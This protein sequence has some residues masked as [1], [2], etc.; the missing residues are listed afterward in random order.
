[1]CK[2]SQYICTV[3]DYGDL[4]LVGIENNINGDCILIVNVYLPCDSPE[5]S[6]VLLS[7]LSKINYIIECFPSPYVYVTG[8]FNANL[9]L[10][11]SKSICSNFGKELYDF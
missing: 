11:E 6:D 9:L 8:D 7:F 1:M 4:R 5:N 10:N 3:I 2:T